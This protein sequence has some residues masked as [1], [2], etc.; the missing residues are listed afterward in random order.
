MQLRWCP[1]GV[2]ALAI[3][4]AVLA[5][6][7]S[8]ETLR[9]PAYPLVVQNPYF[10][11]WSTGDKLTDGWPRHWTGA[12]NGMSG[13]LRVDDKAFR[14]CG[15]QP[16]NVPAAE[17]TR[18]DFTATSTQY[19]FEAGGVQLNVRFVTP[20]L[21]SDPDLAS[22]AITFVLAAVSSRDGRE[23]DVAVYLD[24]TGEWCVHDPSQVVGWTRLRVA[25]ADTLRMG[26][27]DQPV[28]ERRGDQVRIDWGY[29]NLTVPAEPNAGVQTA[30]APHE[31]ARVAFATRGALPDTDDLRQPRPANDNWPVLAGMTHFSKLGGDVR[32]AVFVLSYD[33][34]QNIELL[35]RRLLPYWARD[36]KTFA[37]ML[38]ESI[39]KRDEILRACEKYDLTLRERLAR[40][41]SPKL[42]RVC[43]LANR[44]VMAAHG[45]SADFDGSLLMFA[46]ENTSNGCIST[47]DVFFPTAPFYLAMNPDLLE[48]NIRPVF[49]YAISKRWK[50]PFAP[51]DLGTYPQA[52]G[53]VYGGGERTEEDQ[54][55]VE[56]CGNMLILTAALA[57]AKPGWQPP[58]DWWPALDKWAAYLKE[59]GLDPS[60]QLC[61]DDFA[62]HLARNA[63]LAVKA[64]VGMGGYAELCKQGGRT[65]EAAE[66]AAL[67][68]DYAAKWLKLAE[69][70]D[71]TAL[72]HE[73]PDTWSL[74]YNM[75]WDRYLELHLFSDATRQREIAWYKK[76]LKQFGVP[77]DNRAEYTKPEWL[78]WAACLAD[79]RADFDALTAPIFD[80]ANQ[81]P[82]RVP[83]TDWYMT[84]DGKNRGMYTRSVVG[85][86]W[87]PLLLPGQ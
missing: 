65:K 8:D 18:V 41:M 79:S 38:D 60:N 69:A 57:R 73:K 21:A 16:G 80:L 78:V 33:E 63:N 76:Q 9:A 44:Q 61:T 71:H 25:G 45:L 28:C 23:H 72:V 86:M 50:F 40:S 1:I 34:R 47:V 85:G 77:M 6:P 35:R 7:P 55:P 10:S 27:L 13:L 75:F 36:G 53:Q 52:N 59:N 48:S 37:T 4:W 20:A 68:H 30:I 58:H 56:E 39:R 70:G 87:A 32:T 46:K 22:R 15:P 49:Q 11:V 84:T 62:G 51:H 26:S 17:Q 5:A 24:L 42:A 31:A 29:L 82:D 66:Y 2:V 81:T 43:E 64:I 54:M 3:N 67:A 19:T 83:L 12:I 74:K 14:W